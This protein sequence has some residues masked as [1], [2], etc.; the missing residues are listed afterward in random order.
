MAR[1]EQ[2]HKTGAH[3]LACRRFIAE[4]KMFQG[5]TID[6]KPLTW[7]QFS[8]DLSS[9]SDADLRLPKHYEIGPVSAE[10]ETELRRV[11]SSTF[12]L[13]PAWNPAIAETMQTIQPWLD[14]A[15][16]SETTTC[17]A[18]RHGTRIIGAT[19]I[20]TDPSADSHLIPGPCVLMEYRNRGFGTALLKASFERLHQAGI[21]KAIAIT[22]ASAPVTKF[23]YPKFGGVASAM[24]I[25]TLLAA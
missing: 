8:W 3:S 1:E 24:K 19:V 20:S 5:K 15:F 4:A 25:S 9:F 2:N 11:F 7:I 22:R 10:D 6:M 14:R 21:A 18:L 23:L 13:D 12:L 16:G 17:L